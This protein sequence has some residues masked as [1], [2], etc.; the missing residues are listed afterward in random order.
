MIIE[1][2]EFTAADRDR[3]D[4]YDRL[5]DRIIVCVCAAVALAMALGWM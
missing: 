1:R 3:Y 5:A 2:F 4:R